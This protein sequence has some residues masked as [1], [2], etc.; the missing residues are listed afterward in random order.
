MI[1]IAIGLVTNEDGHVLMVRKRGSDTFIQPGGK[2]AE[3]EAA[4]AALEREVR[5]ELG[6]SLETGA[7]WLGDF[8][9]AAA[10]EPGETVQGTLYRAKLA[11]GPEPAAEIEEIAWIDP[12][13]PG[14][15]PLAPLALENVLPRALAAPQPRPLLRAAAP[16]DLPE[17]T[18]IYEHNVLSGIATFEE[19]PPDVAEMTRRFEAISE[20]G[21][22]YVVAVREGRVTG[23]AYAS[24]YRPRSA[25]RFTVENSVYVSATA[26]R[27]G[28]GRLLLDELVA[29]CRRG[30]W[31]QM[32]AVIGDSGNTGSI[33]LHEAAGFRHAGVFRDV[34]FKFGHWVDTVQMQLALH[35]DAAGG[36]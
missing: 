21:Y 28:L 24:A 11:G 35:D 33:R 32:I 17:I 30:P 7:T 16:D 27:Q 15:R 8:M 12:A 23:Y 20:Q 29:R 9:A 26:Q 4:L 19:V 22:P 5:E 1:R 31:R 10:N 18:L 34:G 25:Y 14:T 2:L 36:S 13:A 3:G 6:T